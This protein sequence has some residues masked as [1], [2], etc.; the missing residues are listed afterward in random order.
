MSIELIEVATG[1]KLG[2]NTSKEAKVVTD[3]D[4]SS[5]GIFSENDN[6]SVTGVKYMKSPETDDDYRLRVAVDHPMDSET[7]NYTAQNT[8]KHNFLNTTMAAAW[9]AAGLNTNSGNITTTTTGL[10]FRTYAYF[11]V[12]GPAILNTEVEASFSALPTANTIIDFGLFID[13]GTNPYAPSDGMYFRLTSAGLSA[14]INN[15]GSETVQLLDFTYEINRVYQFLIISHE[16][17][18]EFWIENTLYHSHQTPVGQGQP[19]MSGALPF[20]I[21]HSIT[22]GAAGAALSM[23][24]KDY[25]VSL[26]GIFVSDE[27]GTVGNRM[28]G[29]YRGLSGGTMGSLANFANSANPTA[30]VPTNT[31]AALGS[32]LGGQFWE[33]D[34]LAANT[35]GIISSYQVPAGTANVAGKRLK[36][37]GVSITSIIQTTLTGGGYNAVWSLA[38]G[39]TAVSLATAEG[40]ASKAP[41]R[42]PLGAQSV[43]SGAAVPV[44]LE[45]VSI[46]FANP[47]Y[48]NPGEFIQTVKKKIGTAPS[49]GVIAHYITFDYSWE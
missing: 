31:T 34:T 47:V 20:A 6:G 3:K 46:A 8:G 11:P 18:T 4:R 43:V 21:R 7:F 26:S 13:A 19:V 45:V 22:G 12:I 42:I 2:V 1:N 9:T 24:V 41:T 49:G 5:T 33:T 39:H 35:D 25:N 37:N 32:G 48:V 44:K 36:V 38:F 14:V 15:N 17:E 10:R 27:L 16:R 23:L 40:A 30:A 29:S 28:F